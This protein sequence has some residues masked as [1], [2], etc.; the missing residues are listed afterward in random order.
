VSTGDA[1][2]V[3]VYAVSKEARGCGPNLP[4]KAGVVARSASHAGVSSATGIQLLVAEDTRR[5]ISPV[6]SNQ[7]IKR[8]SK[9]QGIKECIT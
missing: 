6:D 8:S 3:Q 9:R 1:G 7:P 2:C 4:L 5:A